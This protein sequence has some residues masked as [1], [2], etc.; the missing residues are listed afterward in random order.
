VV[1]RFP[2]IKI[3]A[4]GTINFVAGTFGAVSYTAG[5]NVAIRELL[6]FGHKGT[7]NGT[8]ITND[9]YIYEDPNH[10]DDNYGSSALM[11]I[12]EDAAGKVWKSLMWINVSPLPSS[13]DTTSVKLKF[14]VYDV[15]NLG[16]AEYIRLGVKRITE[17]WNEDTVTWNNKPAAAGFSGGTVV[18]NSTGWKE[19]DITDLYNSWKDGTYTNYGFYL[20][21]ESSS[22]TTL[23]AYFRIKTKEHDFDHAYLYITG[24]VDQ[25]NVYRADSSDW[26]NSVLAGFAGATTTSGNTVQVHRM[27]NMDG[28][29]LAKGESMFAANSPGGI[30]SGIT[31]GGKIGEA[32]TSTILNIQ[33]SNG[34]NEYIEIVP[35]GWSSP[36]SNSTW[37][38]WDLSS[39]IPYGAKWAD[40]EIWYN[41]DIT[42]GVRQQGAIDVLNRYIGGALAGTQTSVHYKV[43]LGRRNIVE[44]Y[45]S[46]AVNTKFTVV[47]YWT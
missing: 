9:S 39:Y 15:N 23:P 21:I 2:N 47:G 26:E 38:E 36:G 14:F 31:V 22:V 43:K 13:K 17:T 3:S 16:G 27:G 44:R 29:S 40:V 45:S 8:N 7:E 11:K 24:R 1:G 25:S 18:I 28:F 5:E 30:S 4:D 32:L 12:G 41:S 46:S 33:I 19:V 35:I 6:C 34:A 10:G 42:A 37:V 20:E